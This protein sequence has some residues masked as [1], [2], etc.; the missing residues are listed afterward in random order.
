MLELAP[1]DQ[2]HWILLVRTLRRRNDVG[3]HEFP[4]T[5]GRREMRLEHH[6][7]TRITL[8]LARIGHRGVALEAYPRNAADRVHALAH[9]VPDLARMRV[10][11]GQPE[12]LRQFDD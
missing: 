10:G 8:V 4:T 9:L 11:P 12:A 2:H 3:R 6:R 5:G 7:L 1:G